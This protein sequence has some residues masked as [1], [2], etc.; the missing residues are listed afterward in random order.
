[1]PQTAKYFKLN[2][3][4]FVIAVI[5]IMVVLRLLFLLHDAFLHRSRLWKKVTQY[6]LTMQLDEIASRLPISDYGSKFVRRIC[7]N[8]VDRR[9]VGVEMEVLEV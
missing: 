8:G 9:T 3:K 2:A 6:M 1:M 4:S 5:V 7:R